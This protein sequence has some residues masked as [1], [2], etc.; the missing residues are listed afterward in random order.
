MAKTKVKPSAKDLL[1]KAFAHKNANSAAYSPDEK[2]N[3]V[4]GDMHPIADTITP[5]A[6]ITPKKADITPPKEDITLPERDTPSTVDD[7]LE[8]SAPAIEMS[9]NDSEGGEGE[10]V[11]KEAACCVDELPLPDEV[12]TP[13]IESVHAHPV[14]FIEPEAPIGEPE[15]S[16]TVELIDTHLVEEPLVTKEV[17][18]AE[19]HS[20][21]EVDLEN[22]LAVVED[23]VYTDE[24]E[25]S[26]EQLEAPP[27]DFI[28][29]LIDQ[30]A[31]EDIFTDIPE[32]SLPSSP[33]SALD[34]NDIPPEPNFTIEEVE[35]QHY[36]EKNNESLSLLDRVKADKAARKREYQESLNKL[37]AIESERSELEEIM[38]QQLLK[39]QEEEAAKLNEGIEKIRTR[40]RNFLKLL[41]DLYRLEDD[42]IQADNLVAIAQTFKADNTITLQSYLVINRYL[43]RFKIKY[44]M[45]QIRV[46]LS[47]EL[48]NIETP[49][50]DFDYYYLWISSLDR[51]I[52]PYM[53][54]KH[55]LMVFNRANFTCEL[56]GGVGVSNHVELYPQWRMFD[57]NRT[58]ILQ[59]FLALCPKC[60]DAKNHAQ[61][62]QRN[63][64]MRYESAREHIKAVNGWDDRQVENAMLDAEEVYA[65]RV[66]AKAEPERYKKWKFNIKVLENIFGVLVGEPPFHQRSHITSDYQQIFEPHVAYLF[67][68]IESDRMIK[69]GKTKFLSIKLGVEPIKKAR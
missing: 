10:L 19:T 41:G 55:K 48:L 67:G 31:T 3:A 18:Q 6:D 12:L 17:I 43:H 23:F 39:Q 51:N 15:Q 2:A 37:E 4:F 26:I 45:E 20:H 58:Q 64:K 50:L 34:F 47:E 32:I 16:S 30:A 24:T 61:L 42:A 22:N 5:K 63:L 56:C 7:S 29:E 60:V 40:N 36:S 27:S 44:D 14:D 28:D 49:P 59:G 69:T 66:D 62:K 11:Q 13:A 52:T 1:K 57:S 53:W 8:V 21:I 54:D 46:F 35:E 33:S 68:K 65:K 9:P 25:H 38:R